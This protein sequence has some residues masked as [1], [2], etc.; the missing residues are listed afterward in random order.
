[1]RFLAK[2]QLFWAG[3]HAGGKWAD[4][5]AARLPEISDFGS[6]VGPD[7]AMFLP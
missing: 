7:L 4:G 6:T 2:V 5:F 1:M 3:A